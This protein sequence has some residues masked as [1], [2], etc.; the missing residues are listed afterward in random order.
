MN[1]TQEQLKDM[2]DSQIN[3]LMFPLIKNFKH[4]VMDGEIFVFASGDTV[5]YCKNPNDIMPIAT[6]HKIG[7]RWSYGHEKWGSEYRHD[8]DEYS[9]YAFNT[10]RLRAI[11]EV[12]ILMNQ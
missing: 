12:F 10:N 3:L 4:D 6:E 9:I 7:S 1:I 8:V 2:S 5:D 11:C